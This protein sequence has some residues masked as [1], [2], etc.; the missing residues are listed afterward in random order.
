MVQGK[1][2]ENRILWVAAKTQTEELKLAQDTA[3]AGDQTVKLFY[4]GGREENRFP[5]NYLIVDG[6]KSEVVPIT[7]AQEGQAALDVPLKYQH[8]RGVAFYPAQ[9]Y[10]TGAQGE[11]LAFFREAVPV[12]V[13]DPES[14]TLTSLVLQPGR[15]DITF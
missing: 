3:E 15:N 7:G 5:R 2:V 8:K 6:K 1:P 14:K 12:E 11:I 9:A 13:F 10:C 4:R